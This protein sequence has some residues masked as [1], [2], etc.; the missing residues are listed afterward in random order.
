MDDFNTHSFRMGKATD[1]HN[2]GYSDAQI[3][4][5]GRWASN[6]FMRYIKPNVIIL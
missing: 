6:A 1:M 2:R 5:A 3:A 4:K